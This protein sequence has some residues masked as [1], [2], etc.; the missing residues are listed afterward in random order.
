MPPLALTD[1]KMLAIQRHAKPLQ[2]QDRSTYVQCVAELLTGY[3]EI[4]DGLVFRAARQAQREYFHAPVDTEH[5]P[6]P[7]RKVTAQR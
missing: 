2:P 4:G 1:D 6:L 3:A 7:L 5:V